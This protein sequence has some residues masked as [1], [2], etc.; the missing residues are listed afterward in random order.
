VSRFILRAGQCV[1]INKGRL[2]AFRKV[3]NEPLPADDC[4][5]KLRANL[6]IP[7]TNEPVI[8]PGKPEVLCVSVAWDWMFRGVTAPGI[9][10]EIVNT[11]ECAALNRKHGAM[12]LAIPELSLIQMARTLAPKVEE[13]TSTSGKGNTSTAGQY[14]ESFV[15]F[16]NNP[17]RPVEVG[18]GFMPDP[19]VIC[20]GIFP[21][22]Q[23]VVKQ[24][25]HAI[26]VAESLKSKS[27]ERC[28][29]VSVAKNPNAWENP[30]NHPLDP[31]GN[32]DFFCKLCS[33][34]LS[35][36]YL[37]CDGCEILLSKVSLTVS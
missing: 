31:Y 17:G 19:S 21:A 5:A 34:E 11:I 7:G 37:H 20:K 25:I 16:S 36:V 29:R 32:T 27:F 9:N 2:H 35:N 22:L 6:M 13:K 24:H 1:H 26:N 15:G 18:K 30:V 10:R 28:K 3:T 4:H 8:G 14:R 23:Y 33:K 12:S